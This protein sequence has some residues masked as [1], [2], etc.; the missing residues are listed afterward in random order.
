METQV[1]FYKIRTLAERFSATSDFVCKNGKVWVKNILP[2]GLALALLMGYFTQCNVQ[3][4]YAMIENSADIRS[5]YTLADAGTAIVSLLFSLFICSMSGAILSKYVEGSLRPE[6]GWADLKGRF[7]SIAGKLFVQYC[8]VALVILAV[9]LILTVPL[10]LLAAGSFSVMAGM[11]FALV[12]LLILVLVIVL[13][14]AFS[15]IQYPV[16]LE[17]MSAWKSIQKGFRKGFRYWGS[18]FVTCLLGLVIVGVITYILTM[19]WILYTIFAVESVGWIE[20]LLLAL[21][22]VGLLCL[23]P[24]YIIFMAFQYTSITEREKS[25]FPPEPSVESGERL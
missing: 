1:E 15:L 22:Y 10:A 4:I 19:P 3:K 23:I 11:L 21:I 2:V 14:P 24:L 6:T 9:M 13:L 7:F 17:S 5:G 16:Y 25:K 12:F 8:I 18:T 20:S